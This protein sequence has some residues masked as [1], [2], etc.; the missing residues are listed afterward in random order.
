MKRISSYFLCLVTTVTLC[1]GTGASVTAPAAAANKPVLALSAPLKGKKLIQIGQD[2]PDTAYIRKHIRE[3]EQTPFDGIAIVPT[4]KIGGKTGSMMWGSWFA[5]RKWEYENFRHVVED[6]RAAAPKRFTDNFLFITRATLDMKYDDGSV[7]KLTPTD[8]LSDEFQTTIDNLALAARISKD[9]GLKG[10]AFD[11]E[12]Y[13]GTNYAKW[14]QA[15]N[16]GLATADGVTASFEE[17]QAKVHLRGKQIMQAITRQYPDITIMI[18]P[19]YYETAEVTMGWASKYNPALKGLATSEYSLFPA[20]LDGLVEGAGPKVK[21]L[22]C[23][24]ESYGYTIDSQFNAERKHVE[25]VKHRLSRLTEAQK[26]RMG[27]AFGIWLDHRGWSQEA[28]YYANHFTPGEFQHSL[29]NAMKNS[30]G[31]AWIWCEQ[32]VFW[33]NSGHRN[34][35]ATVP[36]AYKTAIANSKKGQPLSFRR[37][38]RGA[39]K[40]PLPLSATKLPD[41]SDEKT[42]GPL[43][44]DY[45]YVLDLPKRWQFLADD[46]DVGVGKYSA[47]GYDAG[48]WPRIEIGDYFEN[49]GYK[50]NG[51]AWYRTEFTIPKELE[52][53]PVSLHFGGIAG[54]PHIYVNNT[55]VT[56]LDALG[57][58]VR[59]WDITPKALYGQKNVV[60]VQIHN[61]AGPGG[62]FKSVKLAVRR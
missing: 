37:D 36:A 46:L 11:F 45:Q 48:H 19:S 57:N 61:P 21:F 24:E 54:S 29:Y 51:M 30:D 52:G 27:I 56:P 18:L 42:F 38:N 55:W 31:Y 35:A 15:F 43:E 33:P 17:C 41:Y 14:R 7:D 59:I 44:K 22:N 53:K 13:G 3:M 1:L 62:I 34:S 9:A 12:Q 39:D 26:K 8:W 4:V 20:F 25:D 60:L 49:R 5:P 28:P 23:N 50:F 6:M 32:S 47:A 40:E 2:A 58:G 10:I 16:Y